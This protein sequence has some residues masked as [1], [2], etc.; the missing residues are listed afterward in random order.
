MKA[1]KMIPNHDI[2]F[3]HDILSLLLMLSCFHH[4]YSEEG[5]RKIKLKKDR[6]WGPKYFL[7]NPDTVYMF[8]LLA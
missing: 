7:D 5:L 6:Y 1:C 4:S 8:W 3:Y 2:F